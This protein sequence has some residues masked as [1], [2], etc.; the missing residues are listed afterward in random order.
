MKRTFLPLIAV[1]LGLLL[2]SSPALF[3]QGMRMTPKDR[4]DTLKVRLSLSDKQAESVLK[5]YEDQQKEMGRS[6]S[7]QTVCS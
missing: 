2:V 7:S 3:A 4:T 6:R 5:I 1:V